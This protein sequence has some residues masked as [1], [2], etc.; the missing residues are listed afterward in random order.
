MRCSIILRCETSLAD[1][2]AGSIALLQDHFAEVMDALSELEDCDSRLSDA[3][4]SVH[5]REH[6]AIFSV[7]VEAETIDEAVAIG[8]S[9]LR[10]AIHDAGGHTPGWEQH[11]SVDL[12]PES[13]D[14]ELLNV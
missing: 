12:G 11:W 2:D 6:E 1:G 9:A 7:D 14:Q 4:M 8:K 10:S 3:D 5:L 13:N